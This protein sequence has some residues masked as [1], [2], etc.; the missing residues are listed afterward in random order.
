MKKKWIRFSL[1][2]L[3]CLSLSLSLSTPFFLCSNN[4]SKI[5]IKNNV[6]NFWLK[7]CLLKLKYMKNTKPQ[8]QF[9]IHYFRVRERKRGE[10]IWKIP[11][12]EPL[13]V[14]SKTPR[15]QLITIGVF[16][17]FLILFAQEKEVCIVFIFIL[18]HKEI[19]ELER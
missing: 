3:F 7:K 16:D 14:K 18:N 19:W 15:V 4:E 11:I 9:S 10:S 6:F 5:K 1:H 17:F 13:T 2:S 8:A 12:E